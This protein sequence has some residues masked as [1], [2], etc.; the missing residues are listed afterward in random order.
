LFR[1]RDDRIGG[2][3]ACQFPVKRQL[4]DASTPS[5]IT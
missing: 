2:S 1:Q 5:R 3:G 4:A